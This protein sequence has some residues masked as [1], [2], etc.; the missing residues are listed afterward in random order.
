MVT[1]LTVLNRQVRKHLQYSCQTKNIFKLTQYSLTPLPPNGIE[2]KEAINKLGLGNQGKQIS[3]KLRSEALQSL[4][5]H[6][7]DPK[8]WSR[9]DPNFEDRSRSSTLQRYSSED[10]KTV[11]KK[12]LSLL[13]QMLQMCVNYF[14]HGYDTHIVIFLSLLKSGCHSWILTSCKRHGKGWIHSKP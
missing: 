9:L 2:V 12:M 6:G 8:D 10:F 5:L 14:S 4:Y 3:V 1:D 11:G 7:D 13:R